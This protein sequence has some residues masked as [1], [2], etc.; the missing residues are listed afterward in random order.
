MAT[1]KVNIGCGKTVVPGWI[2]YD[3]SFFM[4]FS[5]NKLIRRLL[6]AFR[7]ISKQKHKILWPS[8]IIRRDVRRGLPLMNET[9]DYVYSSHFLEHLTLKE[10]SKLMKD[11]YRVLKPGG[12]VRLVCPDLRILAKKYIEGD[13][14]FPLFHVSHY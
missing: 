6:F 12:W 7:L 11:C 3:Y 13:I 4:V 9:V 14:S 5:R 10:A 2:N 1:T 8:N